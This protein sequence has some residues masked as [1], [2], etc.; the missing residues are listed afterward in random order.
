MKVNMNACLLLPASQLV[1]L[2][3]LCGLVQIGAY[4]F[5]GTM[6]SPSNHVAL[7]QPD[8]VLYCQAARQISLG[9]PFIFTPGDKP[10]T[11]TTSHLYPFLLA[12]PYKLG[13]T[14]DNL[15]TAGFALNA[16]FY[17]LFLA[18]WAV[19][20]TRLCKTPLS[21]GVAGLLIGLNGQATIGA[22]GQTDTGLF[23]AVSA[24]LFAA[25]LTDRKKTFACL[26]VLAPWCR[27][28]GSVLAILFP[29]LLVARRLF[30]REASSRIEWA[31]AAAG[32]LSALGV[33]LFNLWLTGDAHFHSIA[34]KGY[35][36]RHDFLPAIFLS[37]KDAVRMLREFFLG[38]PEAPP[39]EFFFL[40]LFGAI[41]AW[42][43]I[44]RRTWL[45]QGTWRELWW[46]M[47]A[48]AALGAV[49]MSSW[50]N[51]NLDRYLAWIF[52]IWLI[53]MA[54][55]A[56]W[57]TRRLRGASRFKSLPLWVILG[58]QATTALWMLTC[59]EFNSQVSNQD[60]EAL[61]TLDTLL[62]KDAKIGSLLGPVYVIPGRRLMHFC[63]IYS[64][65]FL[66]PELDIISNLDKVKHE[67][68]LRFDYWLLE[69]T[70][71]SLL[72]QKTNVFYTA[73]TP[74]TL[75]SLSV[76]KADWRALDLSL[77]PLEESSLQA[78]AQWREIDRIDI[79]YLADETRCGYAEF[80]RFHRVKYYPFLLTGKAGTHTIADVGR[81]VVG[82]ESLTLHVTPNQPLRVVLRTASTTPIRL[83]NS[84]TLGTYTFAY[85]SP[86][87]LRVHINDKEAGYFEIPIREEKETFSEI[88][89]TLPAEA[90]T[91]PT[92]RLTLYGDHASFAY[93]FYQPEHVSQ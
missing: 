42:L 11:G 73:K 10:S 85:Q 31:T 65:D 3:L 36:K 81:S 32:V 34:Y 70:M 88:V 90:M 2:V 48:L 52:P 66:V 7:P 63:G 16:G 29:V 64:P 41:F 45:R 18:C 35:F 61:K 59:Y 5:V 76:A 38:S 86:L 12:I 14:G 13:A 77:N 91:Q 80:S 54:E 22:L 39:R 93:W 49:A 56:T 71:T 33:P 8:T 23:M 25:L 72:E 53:Y 58:Y 27:P 69:P 84:T 55:G 78:I 17:L 83:R 24:G 62:P 74:I 89:F 57:L 82:G 19:I 6:A 1:K 26:L 46:C 43:G 75:E 68:A 15:L 51:T 87:K 44:W 20:A 79:G 67:Q 92:L 30:W 28:E 4:Y 60:Y 37:G 21:R 47:A 40:P 9:Q 50:Q